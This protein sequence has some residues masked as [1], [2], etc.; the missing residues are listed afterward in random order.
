MDRQTPLIIIT[1]PTCSGKTRL[2]F[3]LAKKYPLEVISA[4]SMQ[5]YRYMDIATAKPSQDECNVLPHHLIDVVNPDE[6]FNAG[7]FV[8]MAQ[9]KIAE[10]RSRKKLPVVVGGT[11]LYIK[12]LV[13]GLSPAPERS[14]K[15]RAALKMVAQ[16]H[17]FAYLWNILKRLDPDSANKIN[18]ADA[19]RIIRYLEIIFLT[20]RSASSFHKSHGFVHPVISTKTLCLMPDREQLYTQINQRVERMI[21]HGL[22]EETQKLL[23]M[24]YH[25]SL[26]SMQTLAY[27]HVVDY[28]TQ[29]LSLEETISIIQRDT[30]RYAKRQITWFARMYSEEAIPDS[31]DAG[32]LLKSW[33]DGILSE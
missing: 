6:E 16:R 1:G 15:H 25:Q 14:N 3:G 2:V 31:G 10:I 17:G 19:P 20:G 26:R 18:A 5:V 33:V 24:G 8:S 32:A 21:E 4:D 28:L 27:R 29:K 23:Q 11:G 30:R 13:Y 12:S 22:V 9:Q 7:M